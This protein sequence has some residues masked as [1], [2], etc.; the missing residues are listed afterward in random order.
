M[1]HQAVLGIYDF[2]TSVDFIQ[3]KYRPYKKFP[4][5][6]LS[7]M[8]K[9][10][11]AFFRYYKL[12]GEGDSGSSQILCFASSGMIQK[13]WLELDEIRIKC[14]TLQRLLYPGFMNMTHRNTWFKTFTTHLACGLVG[15]ESL[16][17]EQ[18]EVYQKCTLE[19]HSR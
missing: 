16:S 10:K 1:S 7:I 12:F 6:S 13:I 4:T 5:I 18:A 9:R 8:V 3:G 2:L 19:V 14:G 15:Y 11:R 17:P